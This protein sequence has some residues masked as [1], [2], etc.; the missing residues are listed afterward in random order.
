MGPLHDSNMANGDWIVARATAVPATPVTAARRPRLPGLDRR[1]RA[2]LAGVLTGLALLGSA[3]G[4]QPPA[5]TGPSL[6][7]SMTDAAAARVVASFAAGDVTAR[8]RLPGELAAALDTIRA[9]SVPVGATAPLPRQAGVAPAGETTAA[10]RLAMTAAVVPPSARESISEAVPQPVTPARDAAPPA[11]TAAPA[12]AAASPATPSVASTNVPAA[13]PTAAPRSVPVAAPSSDR[14]AGL[15]SGMNAERAAVGLSP[16]RVSA[17]LSAIAQARAADMTEHG[18]FAHVSP[19]GESW[20]TLLNA[21]GLTAAAGGENLARVSGDAQTS[22]VVALTHLMDSPTHRANI[23]GHDYS[24]VGVAAITD[25][26]GV[27]I[28]VAIFIGR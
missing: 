17:A 5:A 23:L 25:A 13:V 11:A 2:P 4:S 22:V 1:G 6:L 26:D 21:S 24:E 16:L 8:V 20:I 28:F 18:Y 27:S 15:L 12:P 7:A 9:A 14:A 3:M 19:S 10:E